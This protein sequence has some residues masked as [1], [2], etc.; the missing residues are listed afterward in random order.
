MH[1]PRRF[2]VRIIVYALV[3]GVYVLLHTIVAK[4]HGYT[5]TATLRKK[6]GVITAVL[7]G[8]TLRFFEKV[9]YRI[10]NGIF[11]RSTLRY[12]TEIRY[13]FF[14]TYPRACLVCCLITIAVN[15]SWKTHSKHFQ[16]A[17]ERIDVITSLSTKLPW[18]EDSEGTFLSLTQAATC[19]YR[20]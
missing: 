8:N 16:T 18:P 15:L 9:R 13:Y 5:T 1:L 11:Q 3:L 6:T 7:Y 14:S 10:T 4:E 19:L 12:V 17:A 2:W 20:T